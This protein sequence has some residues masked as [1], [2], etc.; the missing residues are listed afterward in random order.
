M[1][2][3]KQCQAQFEVLDRDRIF[4]TKVNVPNPTLC[5]KCRRQRRLAFWPYGILQKRK[6]D[7]SEET[8]VSTFSSDSRF[9][10]YKRDYWFTDKWDPPEMEIDFERSFI[11]QLYELQS[12]TPHFHQLGKN[13]VNCDYADDVWDCKNCYMSRSLADDEDLCYVYR[14]L[15]SKDCLDVTYVYELEKSYECVHCFKGFNLRF[16]LYCN[17]CSDSWFLYDCRNCS[18][19]FMCWNLRGKQYCILNKQYS[20]EEYLEKLQSYK[21]TSRKELAELKNELNRHIQKDAFHRP[22]INL[23]NQDCTGNYIT[24]CKNCHEVFFLENSED[25]SYVMRSPRVK[26]CFDMTGLYRGELC[27]EVSQATDLNRVKF[28]L[29]CVDCH[30]CE[31]VDQCFNSGNLFGCVGLKR[32]EYC[33]LNKQYSKEEY[34]KLVQ[35]IIEK[36]KADGEYGEF[37]PYKFA[38]NGFNLSLGNFYY[39]ETEKGMEVKGGFFEKD[40]ESNVSGMDANLL[41]DEA[42]EVNAE[43]IGKPVEC[44]ATGKIYTFIKQEIAFYKNMNLPLPIY[45]PEYRNVVRFGHLVPLDQRLIKCYDCGEECVVYYPETWGLEKILCDDCYLK[46]VY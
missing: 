14:A 26:D 5:P 18:D 34:E 2:V 17:N 23:N 7:F 1:K 41:P 15:H 33:I 21:L 4:Y 42:N 22:N 16:S 13:N 29:Y 31:Y 27:Y 11:E 25:C 10:V 46:E 40:A 43:F 44:A 24:N 8:I 9:P 36:M 39:N 3:C 12:K 19:C 37:F 35:K 38:Y 20:K 30:D 6:C 32:R 45:Y 28:A